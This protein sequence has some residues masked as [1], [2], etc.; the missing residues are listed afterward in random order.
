MSLDDSSRIDSKVQ[1]SSPLTS[2]SPALNPQAD[3]NRRYPLRSRKEL[4]R[5]S[6]TKPSTN[7]VYPISDFVSYHRLSKA[8]LGFALQL[9]F[10]SIPSHF[11]ED[12]E[13]PKWKSAMVEEMKAPQKN[14]TWEMIEFPMGKKTI[15]CKWVFSEKYQ[16]NGTINIYKARLVP[17]GYGIDYQETF[18]PV[19]KMNTI[20]IIL[21]V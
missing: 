16:A 6:F 4:D 15:G 3:Q 1:N 8:H 19:D 10:M 20:K 17:K 7:V 12:L 5:F 18:A 9:S 2:E 21:K 14:S 11:Q 13:D